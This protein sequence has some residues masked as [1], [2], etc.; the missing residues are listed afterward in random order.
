MCV[1]LTR[2]WTVT[3]KAKAK[4]LQASYVTQRGEIKCYTGNTLLGDPLAPGNCHCEAIP[5]V[6]R[7]RKA[8]ALCVHVLLLC[9]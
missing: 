9:L 3:V 2:R 6:R 4:S 7:R 5:P 1:T 8:C